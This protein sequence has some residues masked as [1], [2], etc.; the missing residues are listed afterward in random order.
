MFRGDMGSYVFERTEDMFKF[1][2][3]AGDRI[4]PCYWAEKVTAQSMFGKGIKK[5]KMDMFREA[6]EEDLN[7]F[8]ESNDSVDEAELR[9]S[10][11]DDILDCVED[12]YSA[13]EAIRN[14]TYEDEEVFTDFFEHSLESYTYHYL[15]CCYAIVWGIN[16]YDKLKLSL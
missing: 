4:N 6:V 16:Q 3:S 11:K 5:F 7:N 10:V 9:Q 15:W 1:F 13:V 8:I 12:E 14:F 2:R